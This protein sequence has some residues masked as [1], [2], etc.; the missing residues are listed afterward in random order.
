M[1]NKNKILTMATV[2]LIAVASFIGIYV[3]YTET[4][5]IDKD[6][7]N[8]AVDTIVDAIN[9]YEMTDEQ[10]EALP[11]TEVVEQT[12]EQENAV[13]QTVENEGFELQGQIAYEGA[14]AETW[15]VELGDYK[16]LT[17]YS[18]LDSRWAN[19][20]YTS[21]NNSSQTIGSSGCAPT[22]A[23]MI[24]TA[25]KGAITPD[26]MCNLFVKYG[27]RSSN[28]GTYLSA[29]RAVADEFDIGYEETYN[30]DR[31]VELLRNNHYVAV[32]C[33]NGLFT[34]GGHL[35][36][37]VGV[38]GDTLKIYDP[39]LYSGKFETSTRRG[40]VSVD[41]NTVYC[42][43]DNFRKYA[44]Y[45]RFFAYAHDENVPT[46]NTKP[47]TTN[48]YTR[49]VSAN[50]GLNVR[51]SPNGKKVGAI[52][53]GTQVT[54]YSTSGNWSE[55]G[56]NRWICSNYLTSYMPS[57]KKSTTTKSSSKYTTGKYKVTSN[58][59]V[60]TGP[61][62]KYARKNYKQLTSNARY[63][64]K[65]LGNQYA[66]GLKHGVVTTVTKIKNGFGL[67]PSGWICLK[68]CTKI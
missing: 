4:G 12:E 35:I 26:T 59:N 22:C 8:E 50:G 19:K 48:T 37:I 49:Y 43:I 51:Y 10:V 56:T 3:E 54:I 62:T 64:N 20:S 45:T 23:S 60:R 46:N 52:A 5:K 18:Q 9:T 24:V 40:K 63:Q 36:L 17:Y 68:Y 11:T 15:D 21:C 7:V 16:G 2:I 34:T 14:K 27:Y 61:G 25:T 67:T 33:A 31:A 13:E 30:L 42:S 1:K 6:K 58:L 65:K 57:K 29:F 38:D 53:N 55:I 32:S 66:N 44:N 47:V 39:Y 28:N 41:G